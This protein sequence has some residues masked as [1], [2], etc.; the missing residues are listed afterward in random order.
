M[1]GTRRRKENGIKKRSQ[2]GKKDGKKEGGQNII[3]M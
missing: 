2:D 1:K 3:T